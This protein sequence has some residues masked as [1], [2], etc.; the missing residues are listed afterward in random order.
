MFG[1]GGWGGVIG[2][3]TFEG[4]GGLLGLAGIPVWIVGA[5]RSDVLAASE[6]DRD[7]VAWSYEL[8]G[9]VT[10]LVGLGVSLAGTALLLSGIAAGAGSF[11][12][13][14][15]RTEETMRSA[16][17]I[18]IPIGVFVALFIGTPMWA[19]GARF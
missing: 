12:A 8:G 14:T 3:G 18:M 1:L 16:G 17:G 10:T 7:G 5:V 19:E 4:I 6:G 13:E 9:I 15:A 2:G 11:R